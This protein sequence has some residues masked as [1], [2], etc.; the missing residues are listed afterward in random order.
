V[1]CCSMLKAI[2]IR[3]WEMKQAWIQGHGQGNQEEI[4][5]LHGNNRWGNMLEIVTISSLQGM[6]T[7]EG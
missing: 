1:F 6:P 3:T 7:Y 2:Q 4:A 5:S